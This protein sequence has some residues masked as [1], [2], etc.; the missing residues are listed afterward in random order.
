MGLSVLIG[1]GGLLVSAPAF[2]TQQHDEFREA[3][4][5]VAGVPILNYDLAQS[6]PAFPNGTA[7][8]WRKWL[9]FLQQGVVNPDL[10]ELC[11][12]GPCACSLTGH[13]SDGGVPFM[14]VQCAEQEL[15]T[16][17]QQH[18]GRIDFAEPNVET[19][20]VPAMPAPPP[21]DWGVERSASWGLDR[22]GVPETAHTGRGVHIYI[23]D[24]G[25]HVDHDDFEDRAIPTIDLTSGAV[26]E[27]LGDVNCAVDRLGHGTHCAGTAGGRA[28][29]VAK[30][31][32]LHAVKVLSDQGSGEFSWS[33][34]ALDWIAARGERPAVASMSLGGPFR[35][36]SIM[37]AIDVAVAASVTVVVAA[38][39]ENGDACRYTPGFVPSAITVAAIDSSDSRALYSNYGTCVDLFAPGTSI[40]SAWISSEHASYR[41]SGTSMACPHVS[42]GAALM[43]EAAPTWS[44]AE[45]AAGLKSVAESGAVTD[46]RMGDP[47]FLL[48]V[49]DQVSSS[50]V[51]AG[52][53]QGRAA[54][55]AEA[56]GGGGGGDGGRGLASA[57]MVVFALACSGVGVAAGLFG[58]RAEDPRQPG[59]GSQC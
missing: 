34:A 56:V 1:A 37:S 49:R 48:S 32:T 17:L 41:L 27:C 10:E 15:E 39:N 6:R 16:L 23:L 46:L 7:V 26:V 53:S 8:G 42:G 9:V 31:A 57:V 30:E 50:V 33:V 54:E 47:N 25:V 12:A 2:Q 38:G 11:S 13:P 51:F 43:L 20:L 24:T 35:L 45:V 52:A 5:Y 19:R 22:I 4:R 58:R 3:S 55:G 59:V 44:P 14:D 29:G 28:Y 18:A 40:V 36:R 21:T